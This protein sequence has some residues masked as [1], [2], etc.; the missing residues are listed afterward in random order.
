MIGAIVICDNITHSVIMDATRTLIITPIIIIIIPIGVEVV[1]AHSET[2]LSL[3]RLTHTNHHHK[4]DNKY[5]SFIFP[6]TSQ[7]PTPP[8]EYSGLSSLHD[9]SPLPFWGVA[10]GVKDH[11][12]SLEPIFKMQQ[13]PEIWFYEISILLLG[14][15]YYFSLFELWDF[16][17]YFHERKIKSRG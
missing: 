3:I 16:T 11:Q 13:L 10:L 7:L 17:M 12:C 1:Q 6:G 14:R 15:T 8:R 2:S 9:Y 5:K 4:E